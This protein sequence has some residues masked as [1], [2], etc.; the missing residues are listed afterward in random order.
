M[1]VTHRFSEDHQVRNNPIGFKTPEI[2]AKTTKA[3][4]GF[5]TDTYATL[6]P[7]GL[8]DL[9][10]IPFWQR[11]LSPAAYYRLGNKCRQFRLVRRKQLERLPAKEFTSCAIILHW[12]PVYLG[13]RKL[14]GLHILSFSTACRVFVMAYPHARL[15]ITVIPLFQCRYLLFACMELCHPQS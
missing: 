1:P 6:L 13:Q 15:C 2:V 8:V 11:N 12:R 4:L 3:Y 10:E 7:D 14:D 5:I 9:G